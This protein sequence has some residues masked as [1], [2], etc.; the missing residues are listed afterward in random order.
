MG[1]GCKGALVASLT[2]TSFKEVGRGIHVLCVALPKGQ[3]Q[4]LGLPFLGLP[5]LHLLGSLLGWQVSCMS[6][7]V[8]EGARVR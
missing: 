1:I 3:D 7:C 6:G 5:I 4:G 2:A 8:G